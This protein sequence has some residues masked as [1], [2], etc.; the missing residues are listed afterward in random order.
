MAAR[1]AAATQGDNARDNV[2]QVV[3]TNAPAGDYLVLI[4]H[5]GTLSN[6]DP[7]WTTLLTTGV[8]GQSKPTL[9]LGTPIL[10]A[11]NRVTLTWPSVVGQLYQIDYRTSLDSSSSWATVPGELS[12]IR[13][14]TAAELVLGSGV[15]TLFF[16]VK[17]V[18]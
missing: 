3:I 4:T 9:V 14:N 5:K 2:E 6:Q 17:E 12:G 13:T 15:S 16:R 1:S 7:Q 8:Q 18:E 10:T 11:T